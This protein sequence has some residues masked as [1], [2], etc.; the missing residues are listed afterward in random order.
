[1]VPQ[2]G[3]WLEATS[4]AAA[5]ASGDSRISLRPTRF[6]ALASTTTGAASPPTKTTSLSTTAAAWAPV[7][8]G[9]MA[10]RWGAAARTGAASV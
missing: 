4:I 7:P 3:M 5:K 9:R 1:M 8:G 6:F 2:P 10:G